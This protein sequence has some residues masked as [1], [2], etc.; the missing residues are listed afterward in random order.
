MVMDFQGINYDYN[1]NTFIISNI[2]PENASAAQKVQLA[3]FSGA[4]IM[5]ADSGD[6]PSADELLDGSADTSLV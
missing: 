5:D 2:R 1:D 3:Q 6:P 4:R